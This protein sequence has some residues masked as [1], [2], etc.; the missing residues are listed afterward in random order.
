MPVTVHGPGMRTGRTFREVT[1]AQI[2][3]QDEKIW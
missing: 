3:E 2:A 1:D